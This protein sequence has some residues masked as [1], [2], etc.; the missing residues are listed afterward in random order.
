MC[1]LPRAARKPHNGAAAVHIPVRRAKSGKRG[2][3]VYI[4]VVG[5]GDSHLFGL[6]RRLNHLHFV[7]QPL[8]HRAGDKDAALQSIARL[9][10]Q[11]PSDGGNQIAH[12]AHGVRPGIH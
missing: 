11:L 4:A 12:R 9:A 3:K 5:D 6:R 8:H 10:I 2:Y 1:A 7:A